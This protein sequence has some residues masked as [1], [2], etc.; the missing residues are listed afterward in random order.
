VT[1]FATAAFA[2][3]DFRE[4]IHQLDESNT[5]LAFVAGAVA[6]LHVAASVT[7][8]ILRRQSNGRETLAAA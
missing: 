6:V 2:V 7:A 4:L 8:V 5:G 3:L 1:A